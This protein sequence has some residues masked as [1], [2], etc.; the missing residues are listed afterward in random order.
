MKITKSS[1]EDF[2][3]IVSEVRKYY[4]GKFARFGPVSRG[5]D[6]N[7]ATSQELRHEKLLEI[8]QERRS[9]SL[10]DYGCGY[11]ALLSYLQPRYDE[12]GYNGVD[13]S[14]EMIASARQRF[15]KYRNAVFRVASAPTKTADYTVASGIFNVKLGTTKAEWLKY[16]LYAL[17]RM[18]RRSRLG[19]AFNCLTK[20]SDKERMRQD[21]YYADPCYLF[22]YC[23]KRFSRQI[24][25]LHDY[26]LYEFTI[27]VRKKS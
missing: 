5:V 23:K 18:D 13:I 11:G 22:D 10:N 25:L 1:R 9:F 7:D 8:H 12:F 16:L 26:G 6:W 24:A 15:A 27:L 19:F 20:Y 2:P 21:L 3:A 4:S 14:K 17:D